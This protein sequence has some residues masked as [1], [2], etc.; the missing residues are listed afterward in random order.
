MVADSAPAAD[1]RWLLAAVKPG[2]PEQLTPHQLTGR[3]PNGMG[4]IANQMP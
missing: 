4:W 2:S 1:W 3:Q